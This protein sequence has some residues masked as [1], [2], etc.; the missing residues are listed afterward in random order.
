[1][2]ASLI[3][4]IKKG[5]YVGCGPAC[6]ASTGVCNFLRKELVLIFDLKHIMSGNIIY[7]MFPD[8]FW[9][10]MRGTFGMSNIQTALSDVTDQNLNLFVP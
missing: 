6:S 4:C 3:V 5:R 9:P 8:K 2:I 1:M 10:A 7:Y